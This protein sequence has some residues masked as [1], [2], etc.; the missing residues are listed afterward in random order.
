MGRDAVAAEAQTQMR[1]GFDPGGT[2]VAKKTAGAK[3]AS[4][5]R[6]ACFVIMPFGGWLDDYYESIYRPAIRNAGLE[7][8]RADDLFRPSTIVKDIWAYTR[9]A[10]LLLAD[11][12]GKNPNV[13]YE[14]GLAHALAKPAILVAESMDDIPFDLRALR[15]ITFD[16]NAPDWGAI[17]R[18]KIEA[19]VKEVLAAPV[20]AVLPAFLEV[21]PDPKPSVTAHEKEIIEI[22]QELDL[23]KRQVRSQARIS[24][25]DIRERLI[26]S[27]EDAEALM[28]TYL[29]RGMPQRSVID[30][31]VALGAPRNWAQVRVSEMASQLEL[32]IADAFVRPLQTEATGSKPNTRDS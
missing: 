26:E 31:L 20:E 24:V 12:T 15:V 29:V 8:H 7:P 30:R 22:K 6:D 18:D 25:G 17:L 9:T 28:Q 4:T 13:F 16:K 10:R 32:P 11:L 5:E 3:S 21:K 2:V 23:L 14:L 1:V 27:P 19:S